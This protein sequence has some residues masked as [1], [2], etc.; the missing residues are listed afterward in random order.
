MP[1]V[2][3]PTTV[4]CPIYDGCRV[5]WEPWRPAPILLCTGRPSSR[6]RYNLN[7]CEACGDQGPAQIA[8]GLVDGQSR[9]SR[10]VPDTGTVLLST[11]WCPACGHLDVY[12]LATNR[13]APSILCDGCDVLCAVGATLAEARETLVALG[14]WTS[15]GDAN[16]DYC[17]A[18]TPRPKGLT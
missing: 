4:P 11:H 2:A 6:S 10:T 15:G 1:T 3:S 16:W 9:R 18:C 5:R 8:F 7:A 12:E 17:P 14:G 13:T